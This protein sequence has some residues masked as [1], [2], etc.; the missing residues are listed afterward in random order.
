MQLA[1]YIVRETAAAIACVMA[2]DHSQPNVRPMWVP[3]AKLTAREEQDAKGRTIAT[4]EG[5][6]IGIPTRVTVCDEFLKK[7]GKLQ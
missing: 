1:V 5:E 7:I 2:G 6:R 4:C 3:K